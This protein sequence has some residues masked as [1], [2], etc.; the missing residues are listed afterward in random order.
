MKTHHEQPIPQVPFSFAE[1]DE[2]TRQERVLADARA[3]L[4]EAEVA[5]GVTVRLDGNG[6]PMKV[7]PAEPGDRGPY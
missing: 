3:A 7:Y 4:T 5:E 1:E 2:V 6:E